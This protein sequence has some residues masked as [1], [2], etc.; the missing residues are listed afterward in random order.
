[1]RRLKELSIKYYKYYNTICIT[2]PQGDIY[3][4]NVELKVK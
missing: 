1:M 4:W 3:L 2:E